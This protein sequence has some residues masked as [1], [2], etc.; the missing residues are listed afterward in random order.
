MK[1]HLYFYFFALLLFSCQVSNDQ[2]S[3][4][5]ISTNL[6][7]TTSQIPSDVE[8]IHRYTSEN[9]RVYADYNV[10]IE[11]GQRYI[12]FTP[13]SDSYN[14][15]WHREVDLDSAIIDRKYL[16]KIN[17]NNNYHTLAPRNRRA[18]LDSIQVSE[19]DSVFT[20]VYG[21]N[22]I[23]RSQVADLKVVAWVSYYESSSAHSSSQFMVGFE[24]D[25]SPSRNDLETGITA[26][27]TRNPYSTT[28]LHPVH[29]R[30]SDTLLFDLDMTIMGP[31]RCYRVD[32]AGTPLEF[33]Y[34]NYHLIVQDFYQEFRR[35]RR[36][37]YISYYNHI[38]RKLVVIDNKTKELICE[39]F[40]FDT[41][42]S[43]PAFITESSSDENGVANQWIGTLFNGYPPILSDM[44][45]QSFG[46]SDLQFI[47]RNQG[48]ITLRC[49]NR[50]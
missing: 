19:T 12:S 45:Y 32:S 36:D 2:N 17:A 29:W 34:Q 30:K 38:L 8:T 49:D 3:S 37:E 15:H 40:Y 35:K 16:G 26:V 25:S 24:I 21:S 27:D 9:L 42:G 23:K 10:G 5:P 33:T 50:H 14:W 43:S 7:D 39:K 48:G 4:R 1:Y 6:A 46:C 11:D 28:G 31:N 41:E 20:Y 47:D 44:E 13:L 18:F 22:R